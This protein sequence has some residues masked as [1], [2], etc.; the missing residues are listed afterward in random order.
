MRLEDGH[1]CKHHQLKCGGHSLFMEL[2][3]TMFEDSA[4]GLSGKS[5]SLDPGVVFVTDF[6]ETAG[7]LGAK[8]S[9]SGPHS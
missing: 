6:L 5:R 3:P 2:A 9:K 1:C 7:L 8:I 4:R